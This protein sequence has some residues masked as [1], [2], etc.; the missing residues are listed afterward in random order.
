[1]K[2]ARK[3]EK[4][5]TAVALVVVVLSASSYWAGSQIEQRFRESADLATR[6]GVTVSMVDYQR[7]IFGATARTDVVF[8]MPSSEDP[9]VMEP[10]TVPIIH[11]IQHGPFPALTAVARIRSEVQPAEDSVEQFNELFGGDLLPVSDA[12]IGW[13]GGLHLHVVSPRFDLTIKNLALRN[14]TTLVEGF[15]RVFTGTASVMLDN[16]LL[17]EKRDNGAVRVIEL[18]NFQVK[19]AASVK[20]GVLDTGTL[21]FEARRITVEGEEK[22]IVDGPR[23]ALLLENF[24]VRATDAALN[25]MLDD[26]EEQ[27]SGQEQTMAL[28]LHRQPSFT[29]QDMRGRWPEGLASGNFRIAYTGDGNPDDLSPFSLSGDLQ[30][31]L[32]RTLVMRHINLQVFREIND[33]LEDGEENEV[34]VEK[35]TKEQV[36]KQLGMLLDKGVFVEKGDTLNVDAHLRNG[37]LNLNGKSQP[38]EILFELIPPFI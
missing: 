16:L 15:K 5:V 8:Q 31:E 13:A 4:I 17:R 34:N 37:E 22:E 3:A 36:S 38:L 18:E 26:P 25:A 20:E 19:V 30:L 32:P 11:N 21:M 14:D 33:S 28:F 12:V 7:G 9:T 23:L 10:V 2:K 27:E 6:S 24:D 29:I 1:M 35:E